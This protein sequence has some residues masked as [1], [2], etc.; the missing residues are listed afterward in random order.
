MSFTESFQVSPR[1]MLC[2]NVTWEDGE[3]PKGLVEDDKAVMQDRSNT[4]L[5]KNKD[6]SNKKDVAPTKADAVISSGN[7]ANDTMP[8]RWVMER[9]SGSFARSFIFP[10]R[11]DQDSV[12]ASL[13]DGVL[14]VR[15]P[16]L[17]AREGKKIQ[18]E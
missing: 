3:R 13:K 7:E 10:E 4:L 16:K 18:I 9:T 17:P 6:S 11:V 2:W 12:R 8:K 1:K 14:T 5:S 15:V